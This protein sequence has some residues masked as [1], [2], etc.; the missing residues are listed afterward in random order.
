MGLVSLSSDIEERRQAN[1]AEL[2]RLRTEIDQANDFGPSDAQRLHDRCKEILIAFQHLADK[3]LLA[4]DD[5]HWQ[6]TGLELQL[7][8]T[9]DRAD[10]LQL[11]LNE[12]QAR[13]GKAVDEAN[14]RAS[15]LHAELG[16]VRQKAAKNAV[17]DKLTIADLK[18][19]LAHW[20]KVASGE[21][22]SFKPGPRTPQPGKPYRKPRKA[23]MARGPRETVTVTP[24]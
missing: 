22:L 15:N 1:L 12:D 13:T 5:L 19:Q 18:R 20:R 21:I 8:Q 2:G 24:P 6:F 9:Q 10:A 14:K 11:K 3:M 4:P 17:S 23:P 16:A 7:R